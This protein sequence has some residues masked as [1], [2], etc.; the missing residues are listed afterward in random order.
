MQI[1]HRLLERTKKN[2]RGGWGGG[3]EGDGRCVRDQKNTETPNK[4]AAKAPFV[5]QPG[6]RKIEHVQL[7]ATPAKNALSTLN[8]N[9]A[10][11]FTAP[12]VIGKKTSL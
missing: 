11:N 4:G 7:L 5:A 9:Q 6:R 2:A 12:P 8:K 10:F 1:P 3:R